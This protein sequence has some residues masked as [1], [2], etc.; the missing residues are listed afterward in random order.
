[1]TALL[2]LPLL[3]ASTDLGPGTLALLAGGLL[4]AGAATAP[5]MVTGM[6]LVQRLTPEGRLNEGMTL[7]VTA[8]LAGIAAGAATGGRTVEYTDPA[9]GYAVPLCAAALALL[10]AVA[11]ARPIR[12]AVPA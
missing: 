6:T 2:T 9:H 5:I 12:G 4:V 3:A 11:A 8:L 7:A 1:M 10:T